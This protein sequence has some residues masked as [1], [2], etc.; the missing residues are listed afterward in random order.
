M[1]QEPV[2]AML[3]ALPRARLSSFFEEAQGDPDLTLSL[4]QWHSEMAAAAFELVGHLDV[5]LREALDRVL[6]EHTREAERGIPWF[7]CD[8][9]RHVGSDAVEVVRERLRPQGRETRDQIV[10]GLSFGYW[11]GW[12]SVRHEELWRSVLRHAFPNG[13]GTRKQAA[14]LADQ[15]RRFRNRL[16]HHDSLLRVDVLLEVGK[17]LQLAE[18]ID[19]GAAEWIKTVNRT[20]EVHQRRPV[21]ANDTVVI[22]SG[23]AWP[24]Y[25]KAGAYICQT[26]RT[27]R[28]VE[29]L[30]FYDS[31]QIHPEV[32]QILQRLDPVIWNEERASQLL[33]SADRD[34]RR[35]GKVMNE[36][37]AA[38]WTAG[39]YQV[40]LLTSPQDPR[41]RRLDQPVVHEATGKGS[42]YVRRQR[43]TSLHEL[44]A[45]LTTA[46]MLGASKE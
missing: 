24:F 12:L 18:L 25:Q 43:Y 44:V 16:A 4:Y 13:N 41:T 10:A 2:R 46:D 40:F 19:R 45:A 32:P 28:P 8:P 30:A 1:E 17:V 23:D 26:G 6:R 20:R 5:L 14:L 39:V 27:F 7:L 21:L 22:P 33:S 38:G 36:G 3:S 15:I 42:A 37:L 29:H 11:T 9:Y 35:L 34:E 31:K